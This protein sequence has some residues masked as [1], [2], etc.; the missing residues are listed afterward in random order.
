MIAAN[1]NDAFARYGLAME[2]RGAGDLE[3]TAREFGALIAAD[4][5]YA[6]SYLYAGE[7]LERLGRIEDA[8][9]V[10]RQGIEVTTR[11]GDHHAREKLEAALRVIICG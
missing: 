4:P 3:G 9:A 1:P 8:R 2:Y 7:T 10:Y 6:A 11:S 5:E